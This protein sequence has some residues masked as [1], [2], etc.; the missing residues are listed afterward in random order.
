M[1]KKY[2]GPLLVF[3][4]ILSLVLVSCGSGTTTAP[5]S[6]AKPTASTTAPPITTTD[7]NIPKYGGT[8]TMALVSNI[9]NFSSLGMP[10][11]SE[12]FMLTNEPILS[13]DWSRG[14]AGTGEFEFAKAMYGS[15]NS[16]TG[17]LAESWDIPEPGTI[18]FHIRHGIT[19]A[20][21]SNSAASRLVGGRELN[22]YD[23]ATSLELLKSVFGSAPSF[24]GFR[25]SK[26]TAL[27]DW[28]VETKLPPDLFDEIRITAIYCPL[29]APELYEK[30]YDLQDW[31]NTVGTGAFMLKDFV[32]NS[33]ATLVRNPNYW[34]A[35][36]A[37]KGKGNQLPYV[38]SVRFLI[39]SDDSTRLAA[40][41]TGK[42]DVLH[43]V[44]WE[45]ELVLKSNTKL[46]EKRHFGDALHTL[47]MRTD[48]QDLPFKDIN[49]RRAMMM[50]TDFNT[51]A[52][53]WGGGDAQIL[54]W[55]IHYTPEDAPAYIGLDD[56]DLPDSVKEMYVFNPD[57]AKQLLADAGYPGGF[58]TSIITDS[59][60]GSVDYLSII[61]DQWS[62]VGIEVTIEPKE[63][64]TLQSI[65]AD[66]KHPEMIDQGGAPNANL[67]L[68]SAFMGATRG[69]NMSYVDDPVVN[70]AYTAWNAYTISDPV[71]AMGMFREVMKYALEQAWAIPGVNPA[72]YH[73]WWPW[74]KNYHGE[75]GL[76]RTIRGFAKY[77]WIDE[78]LK[79]SMGY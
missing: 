16:C 28:T 65:K 37:G 43:G 26:N 61:K 56:P 15:W 33:S 35:D 11:E 5:S 79:Q 32:S 12:T 74:L 47:A 17:V 67:F 44:P 9:I 18:I 53:T 59:S 51:I 34:G 68:A 19:Y 25:E 29:F 39:I 38:D 45:D 3:L 40:F 50:A 58:K 60:P 78:E 7:A 69:G 24:G 21:D 71:K 52:E 22:A 10:F 6:T 8:L 48:K 27:D 54:T 13:G 14:P 70:E 41:R 62:K 64:G 57:T 77:V 36:P 30:G 46:L 66:R 23:V 49:V 55:P 73:M 1:N 2:P 42:V 75:L 63:S 76:A 20:L 31:H 72:T 4:I